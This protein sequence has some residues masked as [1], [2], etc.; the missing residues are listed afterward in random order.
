MCNFPIRMYWTGD[1]TASGKKEYSLSPSHAY[2]DKYIDVPC[3]QCMAC[4]LRRASDTAVRAVK[5]SS[6][7]SKNCFITLTC[8]DENI[9]KVFPGGSLDHRPF[10]L[11]MKRLR[12]RFVGFDKIERPSFFTG[13]NWNEFPIRVLMCGEY[14]S[15]L[16]RPH[17]HA[18]LFNFDFED[19]YLWSVRDGVRLYRSPSLEELWPFGYSTIGEVNYNSANY[20]ASYVCKKITG[21]KAT[22]HYLNPDTGEVRKPEYI[23]FP[24]GFGLGRL[25]FEKYG[26]E[27]YSTDSVVV[28]SLKGMKE[29]RPPRYFDRIY[30][31]TYPE[32]FAKIRL[33]R[34]SRVR[35]LHLNSD[36]DR[37]VAKEIHLRYLLNSKK[38]RYL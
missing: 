25:Y 7:Y 17:Y 19:K 28:Q 2:S 11:F 20:L 35:S 1:Y 27:V 16:Q 5:E 9:D 12:K 10:Q 23:T 22:S 8:N 21:D 14:G 4:R 3:G 36:W 30:D 31:L 15:E 18:C 26:K 37:L 32:E 33:E 38:N 29:K 6:C 34:I 24:Y 13:K